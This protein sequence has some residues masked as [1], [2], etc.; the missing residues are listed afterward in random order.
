[1]AKKV[2]KV[3]LQEHLNHFAGRSATL[4]NGQDLR[5]LSEQEK[6]Y[7]KG[8]AFQHS[9]LKEADVKLKVKMKSKLSLIKRCAVEAQKRELKTHLGLGIKC[10]C[11]DGDRRGHENTYEAN[12]Y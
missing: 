1:M 2:V 11:P 7:P 10:I 3:K 9:L 5:S 6:N 8:F 4:K 12:R